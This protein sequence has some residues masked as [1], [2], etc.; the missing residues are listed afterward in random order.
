VFRIFA[1]VADVLF[2]LISSLIV[3]VLYEEQ[4]QAFAPWL[5]EA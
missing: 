3:I 5:S 4:E 2:Q 1:C